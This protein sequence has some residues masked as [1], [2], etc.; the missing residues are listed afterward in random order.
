MAVSTLS[1][2]RQNFHA[3][4]E[5]AINKQ[6][7]LELYASYVYLSLGYY[8][9]RADVA[10]KGISHYFMQSS[11][12]ERGHAKKLM[13]YLN[14]RGGKIILED[15]KTPPRQEWGNAEEAFQVALQL[16][17]DVNESLLNVHAIAS[18]HKDANL[19]DFLET[20]YL[21]EQVDSIK[22]IGDLLTNV[23]RVG[24]GL[25]IFVFDKELKS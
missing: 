21:Q 9:D 16:E 23:R 13:T 8:F 1:F 7:N 19:C 25:G 10:L 12:D 22:S 18:S 3:D 15:I 2:I 11:D 14:K 20:E 5:S 4:S 24:E 6:I 17:R